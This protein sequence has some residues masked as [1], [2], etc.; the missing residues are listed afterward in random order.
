MNYRNFLASFAGQLLL[1]NRSIQPQA[2]K[3]IAYLSRRLWFRS[4]QNLHLHR[5]TQNGWP[6][7]MPLARFKPAGA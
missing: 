5:K 3:K 4:F 1:Q 6:T 2:R 7:S